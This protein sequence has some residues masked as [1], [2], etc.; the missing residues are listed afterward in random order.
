PKEVVGI[1]EQ[2][3][4]SW[5]LRPLGR[6]AGRE[7][8]ELLLGPDI[9]LEHGDLVRAEADRNIT[10][11]RPRATFAERIGRPEDPSTVSLAV[12]VSARLPMKF[13]EKALAAAEAAKP[14]GLGKRRDLRDLDLVTIDGE[15]ARDFDD[16]VWAEADNAAENSGGHR[17]VVAIADVAHYVRPG[18]AL[19]HAARER[20]NSV[21]FP[22]RV[23]PMLPEALSN[24]LCSLRADEDRAC[25]AVEMRIDARGRLMEHRFVRGIMRSRARL[26]YEQVQAAADGAADAITKSLLAGIITPLFNAYEALA[27][28]RRRRGTIELDLPERRVRLSEDGAPIAIE[29]RQRLQSHCLIEE[30]MITANVAAA[31]ELGRRHQP[32]LYRVHDKPD[33]LKLDALAQYLAELGIPWSRQA[34]QPG[35][36]TALIQSVKEH[37]LHD[38]I[39]SFVLRAQSQ[40]IYDPE[41]RG[42]FGLNLKEYAHFT[43]PIR[44]YSDLVVHRALIHGLDLPGAGGAAEA[45]EDESLSRL[46]QHL[47]ST[48]RRAMEAERKAL[49]KFITLLMADK[50]GAQFTGRVISVHRFGMF[51]ALSESGAEGLVPVSSLGQDYFVHDEHDHALIGRRTGERYGL[52]DRVQVELADVDRLE[53]Q[54]NFRIISHVAARST[55]KKPPRS[56]TSRRHEGRSGAKRPHR[57]GKHRRGSA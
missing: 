34:K 43:S 28:A 13:N 6:N 9:D 20:G 27:E 42:H 38:M 26:T 47:S 46:G 54:L 22:D 11:G 51:I 17:L 19:D 10:I 44:R 24:N 33:A 57:S 45:E 31:R 7:E 48:E 21:Y 29:P 32:L 16:A 37:D 2:T 15:D 4:S 18:T 12:A 53:G 56:A 55:S 25:L 36:F 1:A 40:A 14:V 3:G 23:I 30:F 39:A 8:W 50:I 49:Q 52:G 35:D 5:R 41:N